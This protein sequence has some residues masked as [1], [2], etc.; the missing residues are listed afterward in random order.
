MTDLNTQPAEM[1]FTLHIKRAATG[2]T[3]TVEMVGHITP[4]PAEGIGPEPQAEPEPDP[5]TNP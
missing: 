3:E 1:R 2:L 4:P 5:K